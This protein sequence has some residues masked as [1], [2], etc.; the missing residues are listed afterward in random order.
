MKRIGT[1]LG[2]A[3]AACALGF[4]AAGTAVATVEPVDITCT[5]KSDKT[6]GG[7]Q[8]TCKG[9][10]HTQETENQNNSG[11]APPGRNK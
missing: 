5:N 8:P 7:Q 9:S 6:P 2:A 3:V 10:S 11:F 4:G 1:G